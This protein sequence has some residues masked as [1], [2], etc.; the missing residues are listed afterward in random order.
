MLKIMREQLENHPRR[1]VVLATAVV[2][3]MLCVLVILRIGE[4]MALNQETK[5]QLIPWVSLVKALPIT[6][7]E[8]IILPGTVL[9]WHE[10]PI[11]ARTNGY[12][13]QWFVDIGSQVNK[14][15]LLAQIETPELDAQLRQAEADLKVAL[16][17]NKLAQSTASRWVHLEKT[18]SVSKQSRDEK[19]DTASALAATVV[20]MRA[21]RDR[22]SELVGFERVIAPFVG[23]ISDRQT[24][25]GALINTG[26]NP[27]E[28]KPLFRMVQ[29]DPLR[30]YVKIP[31]AYS[32]RITPNMEVSLEFA[33]H[34]GKTFPARLLET[35]HAV[36]PLTR[37]LLAQFE[38]D[39]K[40]KEL[41]PGSYTSVHFLIPPYPNAVR[42]PVN[43]L[44]FRREGLQIATLDKESRVVLKAISIKRDFGNHI[45]IAAGI[46][47]GEP[48]IIN[49]S[50]SIYTGQQVR[51][52]PI[53]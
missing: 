39:N 41:S 46:I 52:S 23:I 43:T 51:V 1:G 48:V 8:T 17:Q 4:S 49:P 38:V 34:P 7:A 31:Q 37:T 14:G 50:D 24:D 2:I 28:P 25:I 44:L 5:A 29:V 18:D 33:E 13:K 11:Y 32:T 21:N 36:D 35:A 40:T 15:D 16:A 9:A 20:S 45:A 26:S 10:A 47:P 12:V 30:L 53:A 19:V 27:S 22:L 3:L 6:Q 42:L